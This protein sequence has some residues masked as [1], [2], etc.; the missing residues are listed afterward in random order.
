MEAWASLVTRVAEEQVD[1]ALAAGTS[2]LVE[3]VFGPFTGRVIATIMGV[4]PEDYPQFVWW[5]E[6][7]ADALNLAASGADVRA[8]TLEAVADLQN[9][10]TALFDDRRKSPRADDLVSQL[11]DEKDGDLL[12]DDE[13]FWFFVLI[14]LAGLETTRNLFGNIT[15]TLGESADLH[16]LLAE[17]PELVPAAVQE[18]LRYEAPVQGLFRTPT[19]PF[20]VG[21]VVIPQGGRVLPLF[22]TANR[23]PRKWDD[24]DSFHVDA[25]HGPPGLRPGYPRLH[26]SSPGTDGRSRVCPPARLPSL[27]N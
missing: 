11:M 24:P 15:V 19:T 1:V 20:E 22:G 25:P 7:M 13:L 26:R 2:D 12:T 16:A 5:S 9:Y 4:P 3:T 18:D 17:R 14:L 23:D 6:A 8:E 27:E 10:L 21:G